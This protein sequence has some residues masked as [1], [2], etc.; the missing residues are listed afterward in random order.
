M[1]DGSGATSE[2]SSDLAAETCSRAACMPGKVS[3]ALVSHAGAARI[4]CSESLTLE[5]HTRA[6]CL[7]GIETRA[8]DGH[9]GHRVSRAADSV[10]LG[11]SM[12]QPNG[13]K[14]QASI[15]VG[16]HT[17][18]AAGTATVLD[19]D[20]SLYAPSK[21]ARSAEQA[22]HAA[23]DDGTLLQCQGDASPNAASVP[24][25]LLASSQITDNSICKCSLL[26]VWGKLFLSTYILP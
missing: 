4:S 20:M 15:A 8:L 3:Q 12:Y 17:L 13:T 14:P 2:N 6:A 25:N 19:E 24:K 11:H 5:C 1:S 23:A 26:R 10:S 22:Q 7:F 21:H 18:S 16:M 9:A